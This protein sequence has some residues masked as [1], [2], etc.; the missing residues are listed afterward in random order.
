MQRNIVKKGLAFAVIILFIGVS[1]Q[2]IIAKDTVSPVKKSD[3][4]EMLETIK[5][6]ANN[7]EIQNIIQKSEIKGSPIRFRQMLDRLQ[8]EIIGAIET[9]N[10]LNGRI[11]QLSDT[12]CDCENDNKAF[13]YPKILCAFLWV[14]AFAS[15]M[16]YL[17]KG[18]SGKLLYFCLA[19]MDVLNCP[20]IK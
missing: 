3:T 5:D 18:G 16:C 15:G 7:Q 2:P 11:K 19:L 14:L 20:P 4:K 12:P 6:L 9:N 8:K 17:F 10:V 1:F 13:W